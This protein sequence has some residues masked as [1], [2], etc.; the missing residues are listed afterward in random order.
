MVSATFEYMQAVA[1]TEAFYDRFAQYYDEFVPPQETR[2]VRIQ[3]LVNFVRQKTGAH[4]RS[5]KFLEL[6]CGTGSYAL[7]LAR[8]GHHV[9]GVDIS[10]QIR[11]L[12][13][14]KIEKGLLTHFDYVR[15]DW[16]TAMESWD[17]EFDCILCI[18][19]S[20]IHNPPGTLPLIFDS[21]LR[22]LKPNGVFILNG[23]RIERELD[24]VE[25]PDTTQDEI[26]RSG[27]P[28]NIPGIGIRN[29]LRFMFM[30]KVM[31]DAQ[32]MTV[33][34]FYTYDN[35]EHESRR[36]VCHRLM[37]DNSKRLEMKPE[38]YDCF[39][40]KTYFIFEDQL[41]EQLKQSGFVGAKE[42]SPDSTLFSLGKNWYVTALKPAP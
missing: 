4:D 15:A 40:T 26:C 33:I 25:G 32:E 7:P 24:M 37:F 9:I 19:N 31:P 12:A 36:F 34:T 38:Q 35:Y 27:G 14:N 16:I 22:S 39:S 17:A 11:A 13:L 6:G 10:S 30:T 21:A 28:V 42:E 2:T 1:A 5:L 41:I 3:S 29:G 20:L 23:R 8:A 18:G